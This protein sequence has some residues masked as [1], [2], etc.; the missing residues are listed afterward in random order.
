VPL[1]IGHPAL[2]DNPG[3]ERLRG[4]SGTAG[5]PRYREPPSRTRCSRSR[6]S[7]WRTQ[8]PRCDARSTRSG[9]L[10]RGQRTP[11]VATERPRPAGPGAHRTAPPRRPVGTSRGGWGEAR[12][13]ATEC[14][15]SDL[16]GT[17]SG[18]E[19][20]RASEYGKVRSAGSATTDPAVAALWPVA[21]R[22]PRGPAPSFPVRRLTRT[23]RG[24]CSQHLRQVLLDQAWN[25][26]H[27]K[28]TTEVRSAECAPE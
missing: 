9:L 4:V 22:Q 17:V 26:E 24:P 14:A 15:L 21:A 5:Y 13:V 12:V 3:R 28:S 2:S 6:A 25:R 18:D 1:G 23:S 20:G 7:T 8:R 16:R 27:G 11:N 10:I 19:R